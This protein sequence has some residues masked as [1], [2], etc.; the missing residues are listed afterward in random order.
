M[1]KARLCGQLLALLGAG[2]W[3]V[4]AAAAR[5][6]GAAGTLVWL[7]HAHNSRPDRAQWDCEPATLLC[8]LD[9]G[10]LEALGP[11]A[12]VLAQELRKAFELP[13]QQ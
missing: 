4:A 11:N 3:T 8:S 10:P 1:P 9:L 12:A 13:L 2:G 7:V 5:L 6:L